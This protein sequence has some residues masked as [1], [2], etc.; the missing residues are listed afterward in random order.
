MIVRHGMLNYLAP[1]LGAS[2]QVILVGNF[3]QAHYLTSQLLMSKPAIGCQ[4]AN[5]YHMFHDIS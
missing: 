5:S 1:V 2:G 4:H 3:Q